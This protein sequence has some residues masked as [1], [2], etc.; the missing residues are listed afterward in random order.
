MYSISI[1]SNI[2]YV[3]FLVIFI[4]RSYTFF[5]AK[6]QRCTSSG[7][8]PKEFSKA[9]PCRRKPFRKSRDSRN[10]ETGCCWKRKNGKNRCST[11][12]LSGLL[13]V[14]DVRTYY[15][16]QS[17]LCRRF[18]I[19]PLSAATP[20]FPVAVLAFRNKNKAL[21]KLADAAKEAE[22]RVDLL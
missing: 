4:V 14:G 10:F 20:S 3:G 5:G 6:S 19:F 17:K 7:V 2:S 8:R 18:L 21:G 11:P 1:S 22:S 9:C 15:A 13:Q 16:T 12:L